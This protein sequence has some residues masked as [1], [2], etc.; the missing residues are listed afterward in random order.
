M[1]AR[2]TSHRRVPA[3]AAVTRVRRNF[4]ALVAATVVA[5]GVLSQAL[6]RPAGPGTAALVAVSGLVGLASVALAGR[7]LVVTAAL[8][9]PRTHRSRRR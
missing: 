1:S 8:N 5:A 6:A 7:I 3:G 2:R 4:W 9:R